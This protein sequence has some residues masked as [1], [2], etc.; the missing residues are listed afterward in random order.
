[1]RFAFILTEKARFTVQV[2]CRLQHVALTKRTHAFSRLAH[3]DV[4][5]LIGEGVWD[6]STKPPTPS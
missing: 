6:R 5:A 1:M 4:T 2:L 3:Y